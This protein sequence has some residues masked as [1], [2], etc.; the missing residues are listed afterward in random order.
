MRVGYVLPTLTLALAVGVAAASTW[1]P[2]VALA[3][4][5]V[6]LAASFTHGGRPSV[7]ALAIRCGMVIGFGWGFLW[8][9]AVR[10]RSGGAT[11]ELEPR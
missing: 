2:P 5:P 11:R 10:S 3:V 9:A 8:G 4:V 6:A 1:Y 7:R